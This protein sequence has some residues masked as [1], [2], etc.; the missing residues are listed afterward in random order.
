MNI[1][2]KSSFLIIPPDIL[3]EPRSCLKSIETCP[4]NTDNQLENLCSNFTAY[5]FANNGKIYKNKYCAKC[6]QMDDEL[7]CAIS[8][9]DFLITCREK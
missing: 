8:D 5:R 4:P 3:P 7:Y 1:S 6:N 2:S 9:R